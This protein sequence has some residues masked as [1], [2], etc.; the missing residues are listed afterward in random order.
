MQVT[1]TSMHLMHMLHSNKS[2]SFQLLSDKGRIQ[3]LTLHRFLHTHQHLL[4][5]ATRYI[6]AFSFSS[7]A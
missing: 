2:N 6:A 7:S 4:T 5:L 3:Q 1:P